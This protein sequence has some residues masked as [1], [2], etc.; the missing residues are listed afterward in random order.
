MTSDPFWAGPGPERPTRLRARNLTN[1]CDQKA[2]IKVPENV[3]NISSFYQLK[4]GADWKRGP[5]GPGCS[6]AQTKMP[7]TRT[8]TTKSKSSA[9]GNKVTVDDNDNVVEETEVNSES[10]LDGQ[11]TEDDEEIVEVE[12]PK[13]ASRV[14]NEG[15]EKQASSSVSKD[16][17]E[18]K[19]H[20]SRF[21]EYEPLKIVALVRKSPIYVLNNT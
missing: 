5:A 8:K 11:E 20:V 18:I 10:I 4:H 19:V 3:R 16:K 15:A 12:H 6:R 14:E 21:V 13:K 9:K 2:L 7:T 1:S 17:R